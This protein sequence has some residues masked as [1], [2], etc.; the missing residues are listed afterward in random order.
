MAKDKEEVVVEK[1]DKKKD[2]RTGQI[3]CSRCLSMID[4][5]KD[6]RGTCKYCGNEIFPTNEK[7]DAKAA[8]CL[9][10]IAQLRDEGLF[11]E[12]LKYITIELNSGNKS[13]EV[14]FQ[15][16]LAT[17]GVRYVD[18]NGEKVPTISRLSPYDIKQHPS[19]QLAIDAAKT[20]FEDGEAAAKQIEID[21][22][23]IDEIRRKTL[24]ASQNI[25]PFDVFICFKHKSA[26]DVTSDT[27]DCGV[28]SAI[29][30]K[31]TE[32]YGYKV[33]F[34]KETLKAGDD[35]EPVIFRALSTAKVMLVISATKPFKQSDGTFI[36]YP[37]SP[38]VKNEWS[39]Y[40]GIMKAEKEQGVQNKHIAAVLYGVSPDELPS[41]L[42]KYQALI[43]DGTFFNKLEKCLA[44]WCP[45]EIG[46][47]FAK[48]AIKKRDI[49][50]V[51]IEKKTIVR[52]SIGSHNGSYTLTPAI[53]QVIDSAKDDL[54]SQNF[55]RA[56]AYIDTELE[57]KEF[58]NNGELN[59]L[60]VQAYLEASSPDEFADKSLKFD[61]EATKERLKTYL[62]RSIEGDGVNDKTAQQIFD[63]VG[64]LA[65][66][67]L[68]DGE[69][70]VFEELYNF[71][72]NYLNDDQQLQQSREFAE[73]INTVLQ[74][75]DMG[76]LGDFTKQEIEHLYFDVLDAAFTIGGA[77][78]VIEQYNQISNSLN[79]VNVFDL[80]AEFAN[81]VLELYEL[82][83]NAIF[84]RF[85]NRYKINRFKGADPKNI[86]Y[87]IA[88][89][90][91]TE[92]VANLEKA[93]TDTFSSKDFVLDVDDNTN[94]LFMSFNFVYDYIKG[95][96]G[97]LLNKGFDVYKMIYSFIPAEKEYQEYAAESCGY[98]AIQFLSRGESQSYSIVKDLCQEYI[99]TFGATS[100]DIFLLQLL[101]D[102]KFQNIYELLSSGIDFEDREHTE[103]FN[104]MNTAAYTDESKDKGVWKQLVDLINAARNRSDVRNI[105]AEAGA[106]LRKN[107]SFMPVDTVLTIGVPTAT[108]KVFE[109]PVL[110]G[111]IAYY[112]SQ[113]VYDS[114]FVESANDKLS[115][116][117]KWNSLSITRENDAIA[118]ANLAYTRKQSV[119][120]CVLFT[121]GHL[122]IAA[123]I[124]FVLGLLL[125]NPENG[126]QHIA[127]TYWPQWTR[128]FYWVIFGLFVIF[129]A[130]VGGGL[131][132]VSTSLFGKVL[133]KRTD[134]NVDYDEVGRLKIFTAVGF[135]IAAAA[136]AIGHKAG[137]NIPVA[138]IVGFGVPILVTHYSKGCRNMITGFWLPYIDLAA[139]VGM[140]L[141]TR[142]VL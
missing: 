24:A 136:N 123:I 102:H 98:F 29:Y 88:N 93:L 105:F 38:W 49:G 10:N 84:M 23:K 127:Q 56:R 64:K 14:Y 48:T 82:D 32:E 15:Q 4:I 87:N 132:V 86:V 120:A 115:Q 92:F 73:I 67:S 59:W 16:L 42:Q 101:A 126:F 128:W 9:N 139:C 96:D 35:Y 122:V 106:V 99:S 90:E 12:A 91:Q 110:D 3:K 19:Y 118:K 30:E 95:C 104:S 34:S 89:T 18:D 11:D 41:E 76:G 51:E 121:I 125:R 17:F 7:I 43:Y 46:S 74:N 68:K 2:D 57:N 54:R 50:K 72:T 79:Y 77:D 130:I 94:L 39:R 81:K 103:I 28:A 85:V 25:E 31:L 114:A 53:K 129:N 135:A 62:V 45:A 131:S 65:L 83:P 20:E 37:E 36:N 137:I 5:H 71:L 75:R 142:M 58:E 60:G 61:D 107:N 47:K 22:N 27:A 138:E 97:E 63:A 70:A 124:A 52:K 100:F 111:Y 119:L 78:E 66:N 133:L 8:S 40:L 80:S 134:I 26:L 109:C 141:I 116:E 6:G 69:V 108:E 140:V 55:K 21:V 33:F 117:G 13:S 113:Y 44:D 112:H 1:D